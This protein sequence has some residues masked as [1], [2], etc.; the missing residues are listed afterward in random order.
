MQKS[1]FALSIVIPMGLHESLFGR[2]FSVSLLLFA[3]SFCYADDKTV[4]VVGFG[5]CADCK[6]SNIKT[7][8]AFLGM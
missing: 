5:E 8:H 7:I 4:Q 2:V 3:V 1:S 6:E